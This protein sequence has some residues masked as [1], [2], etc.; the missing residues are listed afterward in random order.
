MAALVVLATTAAACTRTTGQAAT[1]SPSPVPV[2]VAFF[3]DLSVEGAAQLVTPS[4]LG[5]QLALAQ[6]TG[7]GRIP[8]VPEVVAMDTGGDPTTALQLADEVARDP[9]FVAAVIG[10][11]WAEP[12][13]VGTALA[14]AGVPTLSLS[15]LGIAPSGREGESWRRMV[16]PL[17]REATSLASAVRGAPRSSSGICLAGDGSGYSGALDTLLGARLRRGA[18]AATV[19]VRTATDLERAITRIDRSG[20]GVVAWTGYSAGATVLRTGLTEAGLSQVTL[21]GSAAAKADG[22]LAT[23]A[24]AGDGTIV[25]CACVDLG[26]STRPGAQRF[27]HDFQSEF[28][29]PPGVFAAEG[30]DVGGMLVAAFDRGASTRGAVAAEIGQASSYRGL[31][32]IYRFAAD[33]EL[34]TRSQRIRAFRAEGLRWVPVGETDRE[35][36]LPVE[37]PGYLSVTSCRKGRPFAYTAGGR[38]RGFDVE[39]ADAVSQRL[40]LR[41]A[42][43]D[44]SCEA[45][46]RAVGAGTL[47]AI[48]A[49]RGAVA[50]GTPTSRVALVLRVG[51]VADRSFARGPTPLLQ[52]LATGDRVGVVAAPETL[53]WAREAIPATGARVVTIE[54][55]RRAYRMLVAGRLAAVADLEP[56]AWAGIER[57][58]SLRVAQSVDA[59]VRD[60]FVAKGPDAVLVAA[61]DRALGRLLAIGRYAMLYAKYFPG[62][63]IPKQT[64]T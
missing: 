62:A 28:G 1:P 24:G 60:V 6:A 56:D 31:A 32:G 39:L 52:R 48:I 8:V 9:S 44:R 20:C 12:G 50:Q 17:S 59:G 64:G 10:P 55:R 14:R 29:S 42:W 58:P 38:L 40:G 27:I 3:E 25:T 51:L 54:S 53:A 36:A 61:I 63:P 16:A 21:L 57:R 34:A 47:D 19:A 18:V 41:L 22:Y 49:P 35:P 46:L 23:T 5:L 26:F 11:F 37:T 15:G 2:K 45:G 43:T 13:T 30:W 4:Y 33:G 7:R